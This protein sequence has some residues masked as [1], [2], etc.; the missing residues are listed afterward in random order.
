[1]K[2]SD[3]GV[4]LAYQRRDP[5]F[6]NMVSVQF[7]FEIPVSPATGKIPSSRLNSKSYIASMQIVR[8]CCAITPTSSKA[9]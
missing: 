6:G 9:I 1:M 5:R 4:E 7:T 2:K 8:P 3:W